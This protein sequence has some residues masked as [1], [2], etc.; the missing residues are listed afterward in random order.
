MSHSGDRE[1]KNPMSIRRTEKKYDCVCIDLRDL[2]QQSRHRMN[3]RRGSWC[4]AVIQALK[5]MYRLLQ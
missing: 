5:K 3:N 4:L 2:R 1:E